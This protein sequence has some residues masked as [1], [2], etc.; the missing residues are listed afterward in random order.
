MDADQKMQRIDETLSH[1]WMVRTFLKHSEHAAEDQELQSVYRTLY[2]GMHALGS[3]FQLGDG[4]A[5]LK[6]LKKKLPKM[7]SAAD[8]FAEIQPEI[9]THTNFEMARRSLTAAMQEI[10]RWLDAV[11]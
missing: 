5:Y 6:Q 3:A 7:R 4:E 11:D 9:S 2:D 10:Q 8:L 1:V